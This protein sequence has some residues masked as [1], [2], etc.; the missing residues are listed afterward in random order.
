MRDVTRQ[1]SGAV[2]FR[3][4][5][6]PRRAKRE[7][8]S[9][10]EVLL[11]SLVNHP[12][13]RRSRW[14]RGIGPA[15]RWRS[16]RLLPEPLPRIRRR[17]PRPARRGASGGVPRLGTSGSSAPTWSRC[18]S[19]LRGRPSSS[20]KTSSPR[21]PSPPTRRVPSRYLSRCCLQSPHPI[22]HRP[23]RAKLTVSW[24]S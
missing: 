18:R 24:I 12:R 5:E 7:T 2:P 6:L 19:C 9:R 13:D 3:D 21:R 22:H 20:T 11:S 17:R 1:R 10:A 23:L 4:F 8:A 16:Q 15:Q 14:R